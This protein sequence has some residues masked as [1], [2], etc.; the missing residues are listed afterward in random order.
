[1]PEKNSALKI[2]YGK[3]AKEKIFQIPSM[4]DRKKISGKIAMGPDE[5]LDTPQCPGS[6]C[7]SLYCRC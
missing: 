1:M 4:E 3:E 5:N 6:Q 7:F 2:K